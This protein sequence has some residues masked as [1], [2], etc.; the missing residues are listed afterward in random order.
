MSPT[1]NNMN[2][3]MAYLETLEGRLQALEKENL[4]LRVSKLTPEPGLG[5]P[6]AEP[7]PALP[8]TKLLA[9]SF[10]QRAFA[11]WGHYFVAQL[12]ISIPI[13]CIYFIF[14]Y[15]A[16]NQGLVTLPTP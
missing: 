14:M 8:K 12:I 11:V 1:F 10:L 7:L 13:T 15:W 2:D 16:I 3:L 5:E 9:P 4:D 6:G